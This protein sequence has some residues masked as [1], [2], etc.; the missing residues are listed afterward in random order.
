MQLA[1]VAL[2]VCQTLIDW[3]KSFRSDDVA[4]QVIYRAFGAYA[5]SFELLCSQ[6][7]KVLLSYFS[8]E[9]PDREHEEDSLAEVLGCG[10]SMQKALGFPFMGQCLFG[11]ALDTLIKDITG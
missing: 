6:V 11:P 1:L 4:M 3:A 9:P 2:L 5:Y 10:T 7:V 8:H